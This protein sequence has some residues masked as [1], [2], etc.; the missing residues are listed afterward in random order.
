MS[1]ATGRNVK[2]RRWNFC[3][4]HLRI[5]DDYDGDNDDDETDDDDDAYFELFDGLSKSVIGV[6][7]VRSLKII[8]LSLSSS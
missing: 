8:S 4:I 3:H 6:A 7:V 2:D 1:Y 5:D